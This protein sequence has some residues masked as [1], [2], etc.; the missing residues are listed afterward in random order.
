M[1]FD[2][3]KGGFMQG[4][5]IRH[6]KRAELLELLIEQSKEVEELR[7]Q[8][9]L[10]QQQ[11]E[12]R[13]IRMEKTG[14]LA[15]ASLALTDIFKAADEAASQYISSI[16]RMEEE[17]QV[18]LAGLRKKTLDECAVLREDTQAYCRRLRQECELWCSMQQDRQNALEQAVQDVGQNGSGREDCHE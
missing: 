1:L 7:R 8:V 18:E 13:T 17:K 9:S 4:N 11:L 12:D 10:L 5:D 6:L 14:T 15:E 3:T 16:V 2:C